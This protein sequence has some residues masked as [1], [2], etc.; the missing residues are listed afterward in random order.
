MVKIG[1]AI[2]IT[3]MNIAASADEQQIVV[4]SMFEKLVVLGPDGRQLR[5][6]RM[7]TDGGAFRIE[8]GD[9]ARLRVA[10]AATT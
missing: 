2:A 7:P 1:E 8:L 5:A 9:D 6:W 4:G 3:L 10:T